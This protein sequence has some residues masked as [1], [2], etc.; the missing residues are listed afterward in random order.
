MI[1]TDHEAEIARLLADCSDDEVRVV[2]AILRRV[3]RGRRQ[4]GP[5]RLSRDPRDFRHEAACEAFDGLW[6]LAAEDVRRTLQEPTP[7]S[8]ADA[9]ATIDAAEAAAR[10]RAAL[11]RHPED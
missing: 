6:Y 5:L 9:D 8:P 4:Y 7:M 2:H 3:H 11:Q 1:R 10:V